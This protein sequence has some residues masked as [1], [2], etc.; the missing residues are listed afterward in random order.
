MPGSVGVT[1]FRGGTEKVS[2]LGDHRRAMA[3]A[4]L[5]LAG[6]ASQH[7]EMTRLDDSGLARLDESQMGPVDDARIEEGR[8]QDAVAR[9]KAAEADARAQPE[10]AK[11]DKDVADAQMKRSVAE[12]D[13]LKKQYA[14]RDQLVQADENIQASQERMKANDLKLKYLGQ[15]V[16]V[17][18]MEREATEAHVT[19]AHAATERAKYD[20]MKAAN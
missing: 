3:W 12:R 13:L 16:T 7:R 15:M 14:P 6:C 2:K 8:A 9:A 17:A 4:A 18:T 5:E 11:S 10:V 20:A 19:T 1:T